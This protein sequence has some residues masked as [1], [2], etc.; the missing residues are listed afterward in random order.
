MEQ[1]YAYCVFC[2]D[3]RHEI[4]NKI[5]YMGVYS[6]SMFFGANDPV[7]LPKLS[8][9]TFVSIPVELLPVVVRFELI[10]K[11]GDD[12]E[13]LQTF[14]HTVENDPLIATPVITVNQV[15]NAVPFPIEK[16]CQIYS[17][18]YLGER[19]LT[20]GMLDIRF[21]RDLTDEQRQAMGTAP[22]PAQ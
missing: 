22:D 10:R 5:S 8:I 7:L 13:I 14:E 15:V 11:T 21:P 19:K 16:S 4:G 17:L 3:I 6:S 20:A 2:D 9:A 18:V 12:Q 1:A